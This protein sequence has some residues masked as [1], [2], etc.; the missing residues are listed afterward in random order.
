[1]NG[2]SHPHESATSPAPGLR[3]GSALVSYYEKSLQPGEAV[4]RVAQLHWIMFWRAILAMAA[5]V[6]V[7]VVA[8]T[9]PYATWYLIALYAAA[10]LGGLALLF[11][12]AGILHQLGTEIAVTDRRVI[13]K[14]GFIN[15]YTVEMNVSKIE[16]VDVDQT[17]WG[18]VLGYGT[19][20]VRG[21]GAGIEPLRMV[22]DPLAL[23]SA[24]IA[25]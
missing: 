17:F 15:R 21:T 10:G 11:W 9:H 12:V 23:R 22:S 25:G 20:T 7:L 3:L 4:R 16:T 6:A 1:M 24:I 8:M 13:Y 18:R 2:N 19:V 5:G 14:R